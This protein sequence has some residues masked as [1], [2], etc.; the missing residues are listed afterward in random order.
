VR[1]YEYIYKIEVKGKIIDGKLTA[2]DIK[3]FFNKIEE[4]Y[5]DFSYLYYKM[6]AIK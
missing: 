5:G 1:V 2:L 4:L 6:R 3:D